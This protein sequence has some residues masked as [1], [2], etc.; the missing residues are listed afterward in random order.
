[1]KFKKTDKTQFF[2]GSNDRTC[3]QRLGACEAEG[4]LYRK[5]EDA[6]CADTLS[7]GSENEKN[8]QT[9][10]ITGKD[11]KGYASVRPYLFGAGSRKG[12]RYSGGAVSLQRAAITDL[13]S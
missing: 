6:L 13:N 9:N 8:D 12:A 3:R 5:N 2:R 10:Q 4:Y 1:M 11:S 7:T